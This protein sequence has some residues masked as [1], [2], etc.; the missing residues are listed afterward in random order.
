VALTLL[1]LLGFV[2]TSW[3]IT[4]TLSAA[5]ATAH[6]VQNPLAPAGLTHHTVLLTVGLLALLG[7]VFLVGS[8]RRRP[9]PF[10]SSLCS[11]C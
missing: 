6:F 8:G 3:V 5:D 4:I 7:V 1:G 9:S 11:C 2:V 10:L